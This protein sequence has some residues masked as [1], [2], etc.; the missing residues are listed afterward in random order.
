[1]KGSFI[2]YLSC[3]VLVEDMDLSNKELSM[4]GE[5]LRETKKMVFISAAMATDGV[6]WLE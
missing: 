4:A 2:S 1:M 5:D 3:T 6:S